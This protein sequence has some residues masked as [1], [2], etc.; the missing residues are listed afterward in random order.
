MKVEMRC[1]YYV[2]LCYVILDSYYP[3]LINDGSF[4]DRISDIGNYV[5]LQ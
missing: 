5:V 4:P 1:K 3:I 2:T